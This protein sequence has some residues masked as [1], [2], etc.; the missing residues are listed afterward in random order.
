MPVNLPTLRK[1]EGDAIKISDDLG[2]VIRKLTNRELTRFGRAFQRQFVL[3]Y[4]MRQLRDIHLRHQGEALLGA[5]IAKEQM[6][7]EIDSEQPAS[8]KVGGPIPIR[9]CWLGIG[10]DWEDILG[11]YAGAQGVWTTGTPQ[12]WIHSGTTLMAGTAGN[13]IRIGENAVHVIYGIG[14]LH[15]SPKMES[16]QFT[17]DG[18][19]KP[20]LLAMWAQ[21][22]P[23]ALRI[24]ELDNAVILKKNT[25]FLARVFYSA[26]FGAAV[27]TVLDYP[28]LF[29]VSYVHEPQLREFDVTNAAIVG[30][31]PQIVLVT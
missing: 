27:G 8:N 1:L 7:A 24:K 19:L 16:C 15:A 25:T 18:K 2:I 12:R 26:A 28:Y 9:A 4:Q 31:T 21:K 20:I 22:Q 29:G 6:D 13:P 14:N 10:D 11:I 5:M 3:P 30:A 17:I 23:D